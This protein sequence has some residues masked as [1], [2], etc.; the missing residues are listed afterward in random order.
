[1]RMPDAS[2]RVPEKESEG[3]WIIHR[4]QKIMMDAHGAAEFPAIDQAAKATSLVVALAGTNATRLPMDKVKAIG[5]AA[6]L[7]PKRE[8]ESFL[9]P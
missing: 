8:L 7:N 9:C 2:N 5:R 3:A 4:G 1:M 6:G